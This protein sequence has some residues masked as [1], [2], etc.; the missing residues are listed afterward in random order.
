MNEKPVWTLEFIQA[1]LGADRVE[2]LP[3]PGDM[4][5]RRFAVGWFRV[6]D[7]RTVQGRVR[8]VFGKGLISTALQRWSSPELRGRETWITVTLHDSRV[9]DG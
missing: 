1:A 8:R 2:R 4:P 7:G 6:I 5:E 9:Y 3:V